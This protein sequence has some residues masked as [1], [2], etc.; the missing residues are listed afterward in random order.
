M[1]LQ[2]HRA[3]DSRTREIASS[4][5][6]WPCHKGCD[7]CCRHLA[8]PP[9]LT[10]VEWDSLEEGLKRLPL[11]QQ[12]EIAAR[13]RA[14]ETAICPFLDP[15]AG[16]CRVYDYRPIACRTYGFYVE[17]DRGL[18]CKQIEAKVEA[19]EMSD[20]VWGNVAGVDAALAELGEKIGLIEWFNDSPGS[21]LR[22]L[23]TRPSDS[24]DPCD[25]PSAFPTAPPSAPH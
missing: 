20:I 21:P 16:A 12:Q 3:I 17:R 1:L 6:N 25:A 8:E 22:P 14:N 5:R 18:Y 11:D 2:L 13:I 24:P 9:R 10:R 23:P 15:A 19:G 4:H 7:T